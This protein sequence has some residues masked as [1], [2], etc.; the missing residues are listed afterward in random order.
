MS[1]WAVSRGNTLIVVSA[2]HDQSMHIIGVSNVPDLEYFNRN[3]R[4]DFTIRS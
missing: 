2:D 4:E 3:K 1:S